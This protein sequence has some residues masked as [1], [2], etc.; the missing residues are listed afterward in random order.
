MREVWAPAATGVEPRRIDV[1]SEIAGVLL[2]SNTRVH[3]AG[4]SI[5]LTPDG[6]AVVVLA[7]PAAGKARGTR[8]STLASGSLRA[9]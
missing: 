2:A 5:E 6:V 8:S 7:G 3:R 1:G 4:S 9:C